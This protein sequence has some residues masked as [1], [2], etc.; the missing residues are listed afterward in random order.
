MAVLIGARQPALVRF[1]V[2]LTPG[3]LTAENGSPPVTINQFSRKEKVHDMG[4]L[5]GIARRSAQRAPM[6]EIDSAAVSVEAGI[7]GDY[8]GVHKGR[9]ATVLTTEDWQTACDV[10]GAELPWTTR[11]ANLLLDDVELPRALYP[12]DYR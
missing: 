7:S 6:E 11:R 10:V 3:R 1:P 4:R 8:R 2:C 12:G 5:S 9:Q